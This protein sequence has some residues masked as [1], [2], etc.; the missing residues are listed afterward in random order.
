[1]STTLQALQEEFLY[2]LYEEHMEEASFI[3][4]QRLSLMHDPEITWRDVG[5]LEDQLEAHVDALVIGGKFA[6]EVCLAHIE[7]GAIDELHVAIRVFCRQNKGDLIAK[8]WKNLGSED[9]KSIKAISD[10]L[11]DE[12]PDNW[13][14]SLG[15]I[16]L[17]DYIAL[18]PVVAPVFGYRRFRAVST[19]LHSLQKAPDDVLPSII[20]ALGRTGDEKTREALLPYLNHKEDVV[21]SA[22]ALSLLRFGEGSVVARILPLVTSGNWTHIPLGLSGGESD[23]ICLLD[24]AKQ[25]IASTDILLA[26]GLMGEISAVPVLLSCLDNK[27]LAKSASIAL[28]LMTGAGLFEEVFVPEEIDED[29]LFDEE[30]TL[31]RTN[32]EVP[33]KPDGQPFGEIITRLSQNTQ[34]WNNWLETN[35]S[36]FQPNVRYR[37]GVPY[38]PMC[39]LETLLSEHSPNY[40]RQLAIEELKIRYAADFPIEAD[41]PVVQQDSALAKIGLWAQENNERFEKGCWYF[42]GRLIST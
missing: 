20:W 13:Q 1:M 36:R 3:Y 31:Y 6:I 37:C 25:G 21:C 29:E 40:V 9:S 34:E 27:G 42:A 15:Q 12:C 14:E 33:K 19:L 28:Q 4:E 10:A 2:A 23:F 16:F 24:V 11:K 17:D 39:L 41:M 32:G 30:L 7:N 18:F 8:A 22:A 35:R 38:S 5:E 26:L